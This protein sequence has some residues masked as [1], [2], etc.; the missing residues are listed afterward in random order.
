MLALF[1][2]DDDNSKYDIFLLFSDILPFLLLI[3]YRV[4]IAGLKMLRCLH[5][6]H[7]FT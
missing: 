5:W 4:S 1:L 3:F 7:D 6:K 2:N